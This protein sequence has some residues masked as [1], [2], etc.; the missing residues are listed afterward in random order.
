MR[1]W[2]TECCGIKWNELVNHAIVL[3]YL[4][5]LPR[6]HI[7]LCHEYVNKLAN[8]HYIPEIDFLLQTLNYGLPLLKNELNYSFVLYDLINF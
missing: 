8:H 3:L 6:F 7:G 2:L 1:L 4:Y 5:N